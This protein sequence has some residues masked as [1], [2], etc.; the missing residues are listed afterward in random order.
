[1]PSFRADHRDD[2]FNTGV[3]REM[4]DAYHRDAWSAAT[5]GVARPA[6][7]SHVTEVGRRFNRRVRYSLNAKRGSPTSTE[8]ARRDVLTMIQSPVCGRP[9]LFV[10]VNPADTLWPELFR[11]IVG[12]EEERGLTKEQRQRILAEHPVLAARFY[13]HR[14]RLLLKHMMYGGAPIF[15][16]EVVDHWYRI[17]FQFRG[18]PHAHC[19]LWL[20]GT[21]VPAHVSSVDHAALFELA[22]L[23]SCSL[24]PNSGKVRF[25][26]I[27]SRDDE[28]R[29]AADAVATGTGSDEGQDEADAVAAYAESLLDENKDEA[30]VV[31][32]YAELARREQ[33]RSRR[34]RGVRRAARQGRTALAESVRPW[35]N[36]GGVQTAEVL[37][38]RPTRPRRSPRRD[39]RR[40]RARPRGGPLRARSRSSNTSAS[41]TSATNRATRRTSGTARIRIDR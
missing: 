20:G 29:D 10:T 7:D 26:G 27:R 35:N 36:R 28:G 13:H 18:S 9:A 23:A 15:G 25:L 4:A 2:N 3:I 22:E 31:A 12:E 17:E 6:H 39:R 21:D 38:L 1:M 14:L 40:R 16:R 8:N 37:G 41:G 33:G 19:I 5:G 34:R 24:P 11:R 32:A 30:D